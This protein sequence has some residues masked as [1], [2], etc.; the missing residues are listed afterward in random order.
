MKLKEGDRLYWE[1][2][3]EQYSQVFKVKVEVKKA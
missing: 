1:P 2:V 3:G